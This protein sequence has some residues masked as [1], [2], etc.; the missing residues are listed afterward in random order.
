MNN[1]CLA[2]IDKLHYLPALCWLVFL[3][4]IFGTVKFGGNYVLTVWREVIF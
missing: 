2:G 3:V 1:G 4:G